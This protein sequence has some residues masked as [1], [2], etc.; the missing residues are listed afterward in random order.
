M[1]TKALKEMLDEV[2]KAYAFQLERGDISKRLHFQFHLNMKKRS[3]AAGLANKLRRLFTNDTSV[4]CMKADSKAAGL[5]YPVKDDSRVAGPW[6]K[7]IPAAVMP[8]AREEWLEIYKKVEWKPWQK[9]LIDCADKRAL[10]DDRKILWIYDELGAI[11]KTY[12]IRYLV[13][14]NKDVIVASGASK[15]IKSSLVKHPNTKLVIYTVPRSQEGFISFTALELVKDGL[16]YSAFGTDCAMVLL[17]PGVQ[18]WVLA[19]F[20][21]SE[22]DKKKLTNDRWF[23][24]DLRH[25]DHLSKL[26]TYNKQLYLIE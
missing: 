14:K 15:Y 18:V 6:T 12:L 21:P 10:T 22:E 3:N 2:C 16:F 20:A 8:S 13:A 9:E 25:P 26:Q 17:R 4:R 24:V 23:I 1:K 11:G 7:N 19:N 5:V